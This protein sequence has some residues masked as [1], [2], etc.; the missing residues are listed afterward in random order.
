VWILKTAFIKLVLANVL[1]LL[2][3][4]DGTVKVLVEKEHYA[5]CASPF[6]GKTTNI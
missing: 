5:G 6:H 4:P 2:K 3:L 1:Q